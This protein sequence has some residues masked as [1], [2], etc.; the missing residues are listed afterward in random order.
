MKPSPLPP[1]GEASV[2][3]EVNRD[4]VVVVI[5]EQARK[6]LEAVQARPRTKR[7]ML[8]DEIERALPRPAS[9][10]DASEAYFEPANDQ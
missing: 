8:D 1:A 2:V 10:L 7:Q 9:P 6:L 5:P 4:A 3:L